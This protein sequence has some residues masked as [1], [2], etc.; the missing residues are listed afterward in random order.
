MMLCVSARKMISRLC[1]QYL[2]ARS[3]ESSNRLIMLTA[4]STCH[5]W[6][7]FF[8]SNRFAITRRQR[9]LGSFLL[10]RPRVGGN[11]KRGHSTYRCFRQP[12]SS[13]WNAGNCSRFRGWSRLPRAQSG[14]G[15]NGVSARDGDF[16]DFLQRMAEA[17]HRFATVA[18][19]V[20]RAA[21]NR[22]ERD[23]SVRFLK[24]IHRLRSSTPHG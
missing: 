2:R 6:P 14:S 16:A 9:P 13:W 11:Q 22:E 24:S 10:G 7:Y 15:R 12:G 18:D 4:V 8:L 19:D 20:A 17:D 21:W 1:D 3:A 5:R 23:V